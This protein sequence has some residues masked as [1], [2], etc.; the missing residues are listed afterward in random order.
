M[1]V[2]VACVDHL[3][4]TCIA[5]AR[6]ITPKKGIVLA[7]FRANQ[8]TSSNQRDVYQGL[9]VCAARLAQLLALVIREAWCI[10]VCWCQEA[11]KLLTCA[12]VHACIV[13]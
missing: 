4:L 5:G 12:K 2:H 13:R 3:E 1:W 7:D 10:A 8:V 11:L 6:A 9:A